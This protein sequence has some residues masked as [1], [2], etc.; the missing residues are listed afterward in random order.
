MCVEL[1]HCGVSFKCEPHLRLEYRG[2]PIGEYV[3]DL[4]VEDNLIVEVKSVAHLD[5]LF[6]AQVITYLRM[7]KL[8]VGL[9]INFGQPKLIEGLKRIVL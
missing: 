6:T 2:F 4:I 1:D 5:P 7:T 3:P 9:L 8:R